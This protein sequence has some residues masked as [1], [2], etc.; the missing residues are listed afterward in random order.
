MLMQFLTVHCIGLRKGTS[1]F[2]AHVQS[3]GYGN[4]DRKRP[5]RAEM[6]TH[7]WLLTGCSL[8]SRSK[9]AVTFCLYFS[10][11]TQQYMLRI[12]KHWLTDDT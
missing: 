8:M 10:G 9:S 1:F 5:D 12:E 3:D 6:H 7:K 4:G 11:N 2:A